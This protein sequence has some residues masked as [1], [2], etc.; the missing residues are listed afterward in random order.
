MYLRI[1]AVE[2]HLQW[3][4]SISDAYQPLEQ[5]ANKAHFLY[6]KHCRK[7]KK[8]ILQFLKEALSEI[9]E[10]EENILK[11]LVEKIG[12]AIKE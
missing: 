11:Q 9:H 7:P 2:D 12:E 3:D 6:A 10:Q 8:T 5:L 4:H 1:K